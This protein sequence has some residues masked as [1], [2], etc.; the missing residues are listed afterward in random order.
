VV[1]KQKDTVELLV[2]KAE[3]WFKEKSWTAFD[4]QREAW[5]TFANGNSGLINAPTGSGKTYSLMLPALLKYA[6]EKNPT[7][8]RVLWIT[9]IRALSK[10][11]GISANRLVEELKLPLNIA[12]RTGD[13][14][15]AER[16]RIKKK[17]PQLMITTP[18]TI[19]V[20]LT[21]KD[22]DQVFGKLDA[23]IIDEW[24]ELIGSKRGVQVELALSRFKT[25]RP[26]LQIWGISAT[27]GNLTEAMQVL[28]GPDRAQ[29]GKLIKSKIAKDIEV[30]TLVPDEI[31][32]MP[33]S[34]HIGTSLIDQVLPII[35]ESESTLLFTNTRSQCEIWFHRLLDKAPELAGTIAMHHGSISKELR[36]W[37]EQALY[38]GDLKAVV[39]TSSLDLGVDFRPVDSIIQIGGPKGVSRFIQRAGRSGHRPGAKSRIY[40]LPTHSMEL[41][42]AAALRQAIKDNYLEDREPYVLSHDVLVQY[43]MTLAVS[44]G[45]EPE[46]ILSEIRNTFAYKDITREE[47]QW[48][49]NFITTGGA[50]LGAYPEFKK[51]VIEDGIYLVKDQ[52]IAR[53]HKLS[54]G[55][56]VGDHLINVKYN[57]GPTIGNI[58]ESFITRINPGESFWF[59]GR[60]L[61]LVRIKDMNAFVQNSTKKSGKV[62]VWG[63]GR[64]AFSSHMSEMLRLK[65]TEI[66]EGQVK[67]VELLK[68]KPLIDLQIERSH[69][70]SK[71]E[72]LVE[73]FETN[74]GYHLLMYPM[75]GRL[76]HE[77]MAHLI[78]YRIS[79]IEA[80]S[81][82]M[83]FNDYGFELLSDIPIP[84]EKALAT[85]LFSTENLLTEVQASIN[86]GEM[87]SRKFRDIAIVAGL[88][89]RGFPGMP[90]RDRHIQSSSSLIF[91]VFEDYDQDNILLRQAYNEVIDHQLEMVRFRRLL[92]SLQAKEIVL[93]KPLIPTPFA[94]PI[95]ADR[96]RQRL[97]T[98]NVEE[99]ISRMSLDYAD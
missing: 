45:F 32:T 72:L 49:L 51:A 74:E 69:I 26:N 19:H 16:A 75:E 42:E 25:M 76:I 86:A 80:R 15:T 98:E 87:A 79:Q 73:Y 20:L 70:P 18:E 91:D 78:A 82:S 17:L 23:I 52:K 61:E 94:F 71:D 68:L 90:V 38:D 96:L 47:F 40:F 63:G 67:D 93:K 33:W 50:S 21:Q 2:K 39:C 65:L 24:H 5:Q 34:G 41:I 88:I 11:I 3:N 56:I 4:F 60:N 43:L 14:S 85:N 77:G 1:G 64:M 29:Q 97:S 9:P 10:E 83:A 28:L 95:M 8:L 6:E 12:I 62:P 13:T 44:G 30:R 37:V 7:G 53:R 81:F 59:A 54:I 22:R 27:I 31:E 84:I 92:E 89:F 99:R 58:E 57:R 66:V 36:F 35:N 48:S 46:E 55:T